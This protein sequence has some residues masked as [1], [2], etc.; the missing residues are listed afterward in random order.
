[1]YYCKESQVVTTKAIR[2]FMQQK[3]LKVWFQKFILQYDNLKWEDVNIFL[4]FFKK[5]YDV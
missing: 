4:I 2:Y 3:D 1:M 5:R